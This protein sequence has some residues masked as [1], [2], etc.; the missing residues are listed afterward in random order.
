MSVGLKIKNSLYALKEAAL[1]IESSGHQKMDKL[2]LVK[3]SMPER[4]ERIKKR[5]G[6]TEEQIMDRINKQMPEKEKETYADYVINNSSR[7]SLITQVLE[8]HTK[9]LTLCD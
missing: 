2:I 8:I 7:D 5:D 1:L 3:A 9:I 4:I 6:A